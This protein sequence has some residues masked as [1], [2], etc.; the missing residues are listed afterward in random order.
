QRPHRLEELPGDEREAEAVHRERPRGVPR[1]K[2]LAEDEVRREEDRVERS[3]E[4]ALGVHRAQGRVV[5]ARREETACEREDA[6]IP[7]RG[8]DTPTAKSCP[9]QN[10]DDRGVLDDE[11]DRDGDALDRFVVEPL[12]TAHAEDAERGEPDEILAAD[13]QL[14][15]VPRRD[16]RD[17]GHETEE[18][19]QLREHAWRDAKVECRFRD[20]AAKGEERGGAERDR[21]PGPVAR[22]VPVA[23]SA[24]QSRGYRKSCPTV[25]SETF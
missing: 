15:R 9:Q 12:H 25:R 5:R 6:G 20:T 7:E 17:E 13:A 19:S 10:E 11:R 4:H 23:Q 8:S 16:D 3:D 14:A 2:T 18:D 1:R 21:I 22:G 24:S